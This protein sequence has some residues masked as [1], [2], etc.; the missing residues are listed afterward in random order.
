MKIAQNSPK[1]EFS[2]LITACWMSTVFPYDENA[3]DCTDKGG[4]CRAGGA[5]LNYYIKSIRRLGRGPEIAAGL[6]EKSGMTGSCERDACGSVRPEAAAVR[7]F[8]AHRPGKIESHLVRQ[9]ISST[10][11]DV[12]DSPPAAMMAGGFSSSVG[13]VGT[14]APDL[15]NRS[16]S[17]GQPSACVTA[18]V[19][20][21]CGQGLDSGVVS[22][23]LPLGRHQSARRTQGGFDLQVSGEVPEQMVRRPNRAVSRRWLYGRLPQQGGPFPCPAPAGVDGRNGSGGNP[24]TDPTG[25]KAGTSC[26]M[27]TSGATST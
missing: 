8:V 27:R 14:V 10:D 13:L 11:K 6:G 5:W 12:T 15:V 4:A 22:V 3:R 7:L 21:R 20:G 1:V 17:E 19:D 25:N 23:K 9:G 24:P 16:M 26:F 18:L 2:L